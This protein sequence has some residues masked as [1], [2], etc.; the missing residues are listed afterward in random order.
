MNVF[1]PITRNQWREMAAFAGL[2]LFLPVLV[3][4]TYVLHVLTLATLFAVFALSVNLVVGFSGLKTFGHQAFFGIGA[5]GSALMSMHLGLSPWLTIWLAALL[6]AAVGLIV[7]IP[8]L[9]IKSLGHVAIVTLTFA[10]IVRIVCANLKD[11]T[12]GEMGLSGIVPLPAITLPGHI[13]INFGPTDK[14]SFYYL[15][16]VLMLSVFAL[17]QWITRSRLGLSLAAIRGSETAAESLG[18]WLAKYKI[19]VFF[20]SAFIVG[21]AG[22]IYAHY[23]LLLTPGSVL[24]PELM[25]QILAMVLIGGIGTW[26]GPVIGAYL[27]IGSVEFMR[28]SG[29]YRLL[30]YGAMIILVMRFLPSGLVSLGPILKRGLRFRRSSQV[31]T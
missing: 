24:G 16:A 6:S 19:L 20:V 11:I 30:I 25:V 17:I 4:D 12:R 29:D 15:A 31:V 10:E 9:R 23:V 1:D 21:T 3:R 22:A 5:Y 18:V 13:T 26:W 7:A 2:V 8:V 28:F 27:L 14:V